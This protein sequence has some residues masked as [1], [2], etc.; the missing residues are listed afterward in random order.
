MC[1]LFYHMYFSLILLY[2]FLASNLLFFCCQQ[3]KILKRSHTTTNKP[4]KQKNKELETAINWI[5]FDLTF[6]FYCLS[7]YIYPQFSILMW[8]TVAM[9]A[10]RNTKKKVKQAPRASVKTHTKKKNK[11]NFGKLNWTQK[12]QQQELLYLF[13]DYALLFMQINQTNKMK[14][15]DEKKRKNHHHLILKVTE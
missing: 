11:L 13:T 15:D 4:E 2:F 9:C 10:R 1:R 12:Q 5:K 14:R 8:K 7:F 6:L 3:I